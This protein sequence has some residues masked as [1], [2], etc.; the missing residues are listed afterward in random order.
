M[1]KGRILVVDDDPDTVKLLAR[2]L[3]NDGYSVSSASDG[4]SCMAQV[5]RE[6]PDLVVLDLQIPAGD[7]YLTLEQLRDNPHW[8]RLPVVVL[9]GSS[10]EEARKRAMRAGATACFEKTTPSEEFL[11]TISRLMEQSQS[12]SL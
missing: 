5:R 8:S 6:D 1:S 4:I 12:Y 7:G 9:T 2:R 3:S 11:E 10:A